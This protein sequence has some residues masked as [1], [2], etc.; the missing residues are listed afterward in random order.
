VDK[1]IRDAFRAEHVADL[2]ELQGDPRP[3]RRFPLVTLVSAIFLVSML[4]DPSLDRRPGRPSVEDLRSL[5]DGYAHAIETNNR[6]LAL[7]Y[8][9]P[10]SPRRPDIVA[11]LLHTTSSVDADVKFPMQVTKKEC[12][13]IK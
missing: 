5:I 3:D 7:W 4:G 1:G 9:H 12:F 2:R 11:S 13:S 6:D 8:I 10:D